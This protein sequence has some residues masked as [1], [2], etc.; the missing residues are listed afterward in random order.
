MVGPRLFRPRDEHEPIVI[1]GV[2]MI[3]SIGE[4]RVTFWNAESHRIEW[5]AYLL[6]KQQVIVLTP[7]GELLDEGGAVWEMEFDA[8]TGELLKQEQ[9]D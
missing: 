3:T 8:T 7:E 1:T 5:L 9:E 4:N 6:P 2:G